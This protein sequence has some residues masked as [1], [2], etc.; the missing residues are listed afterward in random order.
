MEKVKNM[1]IIICGLKGTGKTTLSKKIAEQFG[2]CYI[3]DYEICKNEVNEGEI[4]SF[5]EENKGFVV[6]L[7]CSLTPERCKNLKNSIIYYLGFASV[8]ESILFEL[9]KAKGEDIT[10]DKI[11]QEIKISKIIKIKCEKLNIPFI[12]INKDR[13]EIIDEVISEIKA[14]IESA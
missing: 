4:V 8:D 11:R 13:E 2:F 10:L 7:C 5:I 9:M 6:D 14:K 3:S 1:N 12:D